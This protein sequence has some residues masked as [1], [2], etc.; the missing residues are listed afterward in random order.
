MLPNI[1]SHCI[2]CLFVLFM[3]YFAL[4]K[5]IQAFLGLWHKCLFL[6]LFLLSWE[7][8][9]RKHWYDLCHRM[10]SY[11]LLLEFC[12]IMSS[13]WVFKLFWVCVWWESMFSVHCFICSSSAFPT[14]LVEQIV[15][16]PLYIIAF[17]VQD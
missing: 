7:T 15:F 3:V 14:P 9:L 6:F 12:G 5:L 4:Q 17:S 10:L 2:S 8:D 11:G 13:V 16:F 1:L